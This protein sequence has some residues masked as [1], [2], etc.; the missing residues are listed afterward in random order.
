MIGARWTFSVGASRRAPWIIHQWFL[1]PLRKKHRVRSGGLWPRLSIKCVRWV[2]TSIHFCLDS[3]LTSVVCGSGNCP[4]VQV[5]VEVGETFR[6]SATQKPYHGQ[7]Q[8]P[9]IRHSYRRNLSRRWTALGLHY[10]PARSWWVL[11]LG[12]QWPVRRRQVSN[13]LV[14]R[15]WACW[16]NLKVIY[17]EN[18]TIG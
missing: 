16:G 13:G 15:F 18:E 8:W 10:S 2:W 6:S 11:V 14:C 12:K 17:E 7:L 1:S 5:H 9:Y 3:P 4:E